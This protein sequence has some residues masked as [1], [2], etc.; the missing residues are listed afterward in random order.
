MRIA[1]S[2]SA[3]RV[4]LEKA[5]K[6]ASSTG[7]EYVDLIAISGWD[8]IDLDIFGK[9]REIKA[10][11]LKQLL[12]ENGLKPVTI[13][14]AVD[15]FYLREADVASSRLSKVDVL[16]YLMQGLQIKTATFYPGYKRDDLPRRE[17]LDNT[18]ATL[19]EMMKKADEAGA[20]FAVEPHFDTPF[21]TPTQIRELLQEVPDLKIAYDPSHFAMQGIDLRKTEFLLDRA[22]HVHLRDAAPGRMQMRVGKGTVDFKWI[23]D[24]LQDRNYRGYFSIEYLPG[25]EGNVT[26]EIIKLRDL[27]HKI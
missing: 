12:A 27:L 8:Q 24:A 7:I 19:D 13:N 15:F 26:E 5:L 14:T 20:V 18:V 6:L 9:N 4:P 21:Q 2:T 10:L 1:C 17:L 25:L 16:L 11:H 3:F 23:A 22:V